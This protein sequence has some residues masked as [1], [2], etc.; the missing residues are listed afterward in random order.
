MSAR[1]SIYLISCIAAV[2]AGCLVAW[3]RGR[4]LPADNPV[5][6]E[7][8]GL[9]PPLVEPPKF[10]FQPEPLAEPASGFVRQD[11]DGGDFV[12]LQVDDSGMD[13][14]DPQPESAAPVAEPVV[15][16]VDG[17]EEWT[18]PPVS[19]ENLS[20]VRET[21]AQWRASPQDE[22]SLASLRLALAGR[23]SRPEMLETAKTFMRLGT[24]QDRMD[25][26]L[27]VG[28][29]FL[30]P[31]D[32]EPMVRVSIPDEAGGEVPEVDEETLAAEEREAEET[33]DVVALLAAGFEDPDPQVQQTAY[34]AAM[35]LSRERNGILLG[36]LLCSDSEASEGLRRQLMDELDGADDDEAV[37]LFVAAMQSPDAMTAAAAKRNLENIAGR[38]FADIQDVSDWLEEQE[39]DVVAPNGGEQF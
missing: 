11:A 23:M 14:N 37:S 4:S 35:V 30:S 15:V 27:L 25:A 38:T 3:L 19:E 26:M 33:H 12:L 10:S 7:E 5:S 36:Q 28:S 17:V 22:D 20:F 13:G 24:A 8:P 32:E 1:V 6:G 39:N 34:E 31:Y 18:V 2:A 9:P 16:S 21:F 29:E